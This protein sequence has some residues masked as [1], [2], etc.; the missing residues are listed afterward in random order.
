MGDHMLE[1]GWAA[2]AQS[3]T[4]RSPWLKEMLSFSLTF[5]FEWSGTPFFVTWKAEGLEMW[6]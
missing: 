3:G 5:S 2:A 4:L 1:R 6:R